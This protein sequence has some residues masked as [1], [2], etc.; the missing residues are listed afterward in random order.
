MPEAEYA[1]AQAAIYLSL[2]PKSDA[3][4]RAIHAARAYVRDEGAGLPPQELA[5]RDAALGRRSGYDNPHRH[6]GHVNDQE[7]M[8]EGR[9]G[10]RFYEPDDGEPAMRERLERLRAARGRP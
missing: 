1:L 2:A 7:H 4:K 9:E 8:P 10:A 5:F 3:V 6:P